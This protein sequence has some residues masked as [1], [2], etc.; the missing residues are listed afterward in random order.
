MLAHVGSRRHWLRGR[1]G[2]ASRR[3]HAAVGKE[4]RAK[5][6]ACALHRTARA[7]FVWR[8]LSRHV[9]SKDTH[10]LPRCLWGNE[11]VRQNTPCIVS[12]Q[13]FLFGS[14]CLPQDLSD[15]A[16][17]R[18][19]GKNCVGRPM[20]NAISSPR[21]CQGLTGT[22]RDVRRTSGQERPCTPRAWQHARVT[23]NDARETP[24]GTRS[25]V[26]ASG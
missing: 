5:R 16:T 7:V 21:L 11:Q 26:S 9:C 22:A 6:A 19:R 17:A 18:A 2:R 1:T 10:G 25:A 12:R 23:R 8:S 15:F 4:A 20:E 24:R 13:P 3:L 14:V